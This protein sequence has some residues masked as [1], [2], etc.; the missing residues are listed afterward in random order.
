[1]DIPFTYTMLGVNRDREFHLVSRPTGIV[2]SDADC[3]GFDG[4]DW[5]RIKEK[6]WITRGQGTTSLRVKGDIEDISRELDHGVKVFT[7]WRKRL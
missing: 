3:D 2:V 6:T 4:R 7:S 5:F 1:M